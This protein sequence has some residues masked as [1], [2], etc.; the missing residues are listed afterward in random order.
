MINHLR[1]RHFKMAVFIGIAVPVVLSLA[2]MNKKSPQ[3][4]SSAQSVSKIVNAQSQWEST[5]SKKLNSVEVANSGITLSVAATTD[6]VLSLGLKASGGAKTN[7]P[8]LLAYW[9]Q[10][11]ATQTLPGNAYLLGPFNSGEASSNFYVLPATACNVDGFISLY[12]LAQQRVYTVNALP[13]A[14]LLT[15]GGAQ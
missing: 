1:K 9:H 5:F 12:S 11:N 7:I 2:V 14:S 15:S 8:D 4:S 3:P 13:T 6:S 10:Q